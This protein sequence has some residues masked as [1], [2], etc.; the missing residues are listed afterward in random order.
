MSSIE[1]KLIPYYNNGEFPFEV[2]EGI[3]TLGVNGFHIKDFGGPG[4]STIEVG[5]VLYEMAKVDCSIPSFM[6]IH[7]VIGMAVID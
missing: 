4:L 3:K 1:D 7:S 2:L 5:A 6:I